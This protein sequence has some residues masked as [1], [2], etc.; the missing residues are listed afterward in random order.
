M[1]E[2]LG[3]QPSYLGTHEVKYNWLVCGRV[4]DVCISLNLLRFAEIHTGEVQRDFGQF[5]L[6]VILVRGP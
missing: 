3:R 2:W 1:S 4:S 5:S 6:P